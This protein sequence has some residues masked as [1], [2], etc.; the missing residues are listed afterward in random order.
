[1]LDYQPTNQ[2]AKPSV[3]RDIEGWRKVCIVGLEPLNGLTQ[4]FKWYQK[5]FA[6]VFQR[7]LSTWIIGQLFLVPIFGKRQINEPNK[8]P[9][10]QEEMTIPKCLQVRTSSVRT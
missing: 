10:N 8:E 6:H 3:E 1:M 9:H 5:L 7:K 4:W 2:P